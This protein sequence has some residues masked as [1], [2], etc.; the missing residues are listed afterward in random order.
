MLLNF[1][2][3]CVPRIIWVL[4]IFPLNHDITFLYLCYPISWS[5]STALQ[6]SYYFICRKKLK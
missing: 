1:A 3:I 4:F 6:L 5:I 2:G